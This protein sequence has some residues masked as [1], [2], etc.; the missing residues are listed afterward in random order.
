MSRLYHVEIA[1][2]AA[3]TDPKWIDNLLSHF[4]IPGVERSKQGISRRITLDGILHIAL[5][6]RLN[7]ELHI[8]VG[9]AVALSARL[10]ASHSARAEVGASLELRVDRPALEHEI[11]RRVNDAVESSIRPRRGRPYKRAIE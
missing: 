7:R 10:L 8:S 3:D 5:I 4:D 1:R 9:S 2:F 11:G 6:R